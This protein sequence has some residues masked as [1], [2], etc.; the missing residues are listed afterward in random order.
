MNTP[1]IQIRPFQAGDALAFREL[2]EEWIALYFG[3]EE[4]DRVQ[5]GDPEGHILRPGGHIFM[6]VAN[7][8]PIGCCALIKTQPG[9][10][11]LA[12]MA[13]TRQYRGFGIGRKLLEYTIE[14]AKALGAN[15]LHLGS[16]TKLANTVHLYESF[17]FRHLPSEKIAPSPYVRAN[18]FMELDL[19]LTASP[20]T[21][22]S[23]SLQPV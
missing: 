3:I 19:S 17:G 13:V 14:Q 16:N 23:A 8:V 7:Q 21:G 10:F 18:V 22:H 1:D 15:F 6:A 5:L 12:K 2:N 11:E 20:A 9:V 4:H